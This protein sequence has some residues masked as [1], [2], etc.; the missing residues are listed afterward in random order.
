MHNAALCFKSNQVSGIRFVGPPVWTAWTRSEPGP[1][2]L[3]T[4]GHCPACRPGPPD[5]RAV[6]Y[7]QGRHALCSRVAQALHGQ[8]PHGTPMGALCVNRTENNYAARWLAAS[9]ARLCLRRESPG[10]RAPS[11]SQSNL[12]ESTTNA[13]SSLWSGHARRPRQQVQLSAGSGSGTGSGI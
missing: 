9:L 6:P 2:I 11:A 1:A 3:F 5:T 10:E 13:C 8:F 7:L 12:V 4:R